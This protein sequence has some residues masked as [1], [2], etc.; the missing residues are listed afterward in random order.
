MKV[1]SSLRD[2]AM[3][4]TV[5]IEKEKSGKL[6]WDMLPKALIQELKELFKNT[7]N[8][9]GIEFDDKHQIG[10]E[11]DEE[12]EY[13]MRGEKAWQQEHQID[14][15]CDEE[16]W[17]AWQQDMEREWERSAIEEWVDIKLPLIVTEICHELECVRESA[18]RIID[19]DCQEYRIHCRKP[20]H[21]VMLDLLRPP[22]K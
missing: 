8:F 20:L 15:E 10:L 3:R 14:L 2:L 22:F 7:C 6:P 18:L 9:C 11:C 16:Y 4:K 17:K 1:V 5:H 12:K 21:W 13:W 19:A